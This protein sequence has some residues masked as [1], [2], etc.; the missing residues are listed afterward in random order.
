MKRKL[1]FAAIAVIALSACNETIVNEPEMDTGLVKLNLSLPFGE[2]RSQGTD[3]ERKVNGFQVY[4]FDSEGILEAY[5]NVQT[6]TVSIECTPGSKKIV[7]FVNAPEIKDVSTY[8]EL[9]SLSSNLADN[10]RDNLVMTGEITADVTESA[11][12]TIPVS[13]IAAKIILGTVTNNL[14]LEHLKTKRFY[15]S[16]IFLINVAG[17]TGYMNDRPIQLWYNKMNMDEGS[18]VEDLVLK[19]G[20]DSFII[21]SGESYDADDTFYA[22]PNPTEIDTSDEGWSPRYTRLVL[23]AYISNDLYYYPI[24]IPDL[25]RNTAYLVNVTIT[26]PGSDSPDSPVDLDTASVSVEVLDWTDAEEINEKI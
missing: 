19:K 20:Q 12:I 5:D 21:P 4:V 22:Y 26:R 24:S 15:V 7:A 3:D 23:K 13:R 11:E 14:A 9:T 8:E 6:S 25:E 1:C 10:R 16:E 17:T 18:L 2:T